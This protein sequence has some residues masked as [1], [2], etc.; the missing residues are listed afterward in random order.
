MDIPILGIC[1]GHQ[2]MAGFYGGSAAEAPKPEFGAATISL[3][4]G[5]GA[6][7]E[8]PPDEQ[9]VWESPNDEV[10]EAPPGFVITAHSESCAVQG[11]ENE[12]G[13]RF[14]LQF[15]PEVNDA[16]LDAWLNRKPPPEDLARN[17]AQSAAEQARHH[18]SHQQSMHAW[19][20]KF[21]TYWQAQGAN[22]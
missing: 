4:G 15:H 9:T 18:V 8:G 10:T 20:R 7:F 13:D 1:A 11:M 2:F 19:L 12:S 17:G 14:G 5:G 3:I 22:S 21:L 16:V 6:L